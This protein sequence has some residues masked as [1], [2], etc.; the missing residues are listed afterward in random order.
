MSVPMT[1][2]RQHKIGKNSPTPNV[3]LDTLQSF[4]IITVLMS[5]LAVKALKE[6]AVYLNA[7]TSQRYNNASYVN[8]VYNFKVDIATYIPKLEFTILPLPIHLC[9]NPNQFPQHNKYLHMPKPE[10]PNQV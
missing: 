5:Q 3:V 1:T 9:K 7:A 4:H 8:C 6:I 10:P 2:V